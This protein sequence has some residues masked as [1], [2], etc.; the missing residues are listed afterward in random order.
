MISIIIP[1][2]NRAHS[3]FNSIESV[4]K[5]T[6]PNWELLI[7]DDGS[8]DNTHEIVDKYLIDE[9]IQYHYDVNRGVSAARN[10]GARLSKGDYLI[11]LDSD[12]MLESEL[13][14]NLNKS[15]FSK[16]DLICWELKCIIDG[17]EKI[18]KPKSQGELY[19]N[20]EVGFLAESICYKKEYFLKVGGYDEKMTFGE[21]YE[22]GIRLCQEKDLKILILNKVLARYYIESAQRTS[23]STSN[24]F[25]SC[26]HQYQKHKDI[27][28]SSRH[29]NSKMLYFFGYLLENLKKKGFAFKFYSQSWITAPWKIKSLFKMILLGF[30]KLKKS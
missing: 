10:R 16:Y 26:V 9:R 17:E 25:H 11:F 13:I 22:L 15:D 20:Y 28:I 19:N 14:E 5:Q 23:N 7:I 21:N 3:I 6:N 24:R 29:E 12:D 2:Y 27:F 1:T 8:K 18:I 30:S 4:L